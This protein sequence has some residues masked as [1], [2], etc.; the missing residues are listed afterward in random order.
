M[1][2]GTVTLHF[3]NGS[4][5]TPSVS[6]HQQSLHN[7]DPFVAVR[8]PNGTTSIML[9]SKHHAQLLGDASARMDDRRR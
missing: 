8:K 6:A 2:N 4:T 3:A 7:D 5:D 1:P 9:T